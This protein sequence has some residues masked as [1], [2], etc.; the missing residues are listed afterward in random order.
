MS[1]TTD[2]SC[3]IYPVIQ[4]YYEFD[5]QTVVSAGFGKSRKS[6]QILVFEVPLQ[7]TLRFE[8]SWSRPE[9]KFSIQVRTPSSQTVPSNRY[10]AHVREATSEMFTVKIDTIGNW[11]V[12]L[13]SDLPVG[14]SDTVTVH[15][16]DLNHE[17]PGPVVLKAAVSS[18][19]A[20]CDGFCV[21]ALNDLS[22]DEFSAIRRVPVTSL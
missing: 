11:T 9:N 16:S 2:K 15:V 22:T 7:A 1:T 20:H 17:L 21:Y 6:T 13:I 14:F 5:T 18:V 19:L 12:E 10:G 8:A 3:R 4:A